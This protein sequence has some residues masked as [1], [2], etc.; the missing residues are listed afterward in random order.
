MSFE[1]L[2]PSPLLT[3][4]SSPVCISEIEHWLTRKCVC[5]DNAF[6]TFA[7]MIFSLGVLAE[8]QS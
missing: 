4:H 8:M 7:Q 6:A 2:L 1:F 5:S 3:K